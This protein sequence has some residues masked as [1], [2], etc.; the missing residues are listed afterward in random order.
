[1]HRDG[2][3]VRAK[4][5]EYLVSTLAYSLSIYLATIVDGILV[6]QLIGPV[7]FAAINYT[8]PVVYLKNIV[9]MLFINGGCTLTARYIGERR[10][11]E[12][13]RVF[14]L[15]IWGCAA[16]YLL[17][18][19]LGAI[20]AAPL[21]AV[22]S[23]GGQS[24]G[25]VYAYLIPLLA[26]GP[27]QAL[28]N[29]TAG[30][31]RLDGRHSMATAIPVLAN[32]INLGCD[33]VFIKYFGWGIAG[34]G[35]A[36]V[37]GYL[38]SLVI[39]AR[40]L[41]DKERTLHFVRVGI[42]DLKILPECF[43]AGLPMAMIQACSVLKNFTINSVVLR[44]Y[45][46]QGGQ[47]IAVCNNAVFYAMM[48][49]DG[50]SNA[51]SSVCSVLFGEKDMRGVRA[52]FRR[53][54]TVAGMFCLIIFILLMLFPVRFGL[55]YHVTDP[56]TQLMLSKY[57]RIFALYIPVL[58]P[59]YAL[60][61][62]YQATKKANIATAVSVL[63]GAAVTVPVFILLSLVNRDLMWCANC[64]GAVITLAVIIGLMQYR[65]GKEKYD[66]FMMLRMADPGREHDFSVA[67][68]IFEARKASEEVINYL[69]EYN[70]KD[71]VCNS[72]GV[73]AEELCDNISQ[74]AGLEHDN[75]IDLFIRISDDEVLL[76]VRDSGRTF[77]PTDFEGE[78]GERIT[79]LS[80]IRAMGC[81][82]EYDRIM[83]FN[84]TLVSV[85]LWRR[86]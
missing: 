59:L 63:E 4:Y 65:A 23:Q 44:E 67:V 18:F 78:T 37:T 79:G 29:G 7:S 22:L 34:A 36:T 50:A 32:V 31:L 86:K 70:V 76:K 2:D 64:L 26:A 35:W 72:L 24:Y 74:Y 57:L 83:G 1:M 27:V 21:S 82:I 15:S 38:C 42:K 9:F 62:Y 51:M 66:D 17:L 30:F 80:L 48:F 8:M 3:L 68:D 75:K 85:R 77:N 43:R 55:F 81:T 41:L 40:Y 56:D 14:T 52:V 84:T 12:G 45:G 53:A 61:S 69:K 16:G 58:A 20:S 19:A 73:A 49:A 25:D 46:D 5:M 6:G 39:P 47:I 54:L 71:S 60:R 13:D 28:S 10:H 33:Y 11:G